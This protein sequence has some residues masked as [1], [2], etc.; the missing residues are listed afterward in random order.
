MPLDDR[1]TTVSL[2]KVPADPRADDRA[3]D[4]N[5]DEVEAEVADAI[6]DASPSHGAESGTS[7]DELDGSSAHGVDSRWA[8]RVLVLAVAIW[9]WHFGRLVA[10][11][12][13]RFGAYDFDMGFLDQAVWLLAR[14]RHFMTV[15]GLPVFGHHNNLALYLF[16]PLSWVGLATPTILSNIQTL[17]L[18]L[19]TI[20]LYLL[21][22]HRLG[23][24]WLAVPLALA[25]L[26]HPSTQWVTWELF[27]PEV[28]AMLPL[29]FAY[30]FSVTKNWR[31]F[32]ISVIATI[33]WK[34]DL[35][36]AIFVLGAIVALRGDRRRGLAVAGAAVVWFAVST[37]LVIPAFDG[38][39]GSEP[40]YV[41]LYGDLGNS[42]TEIATN[43]L[44]DPEL[45]WQ[46]WQ[47][48]DA[49][50]Y[51]ADVAS[52]Y[53]YLSFGSP[54]VLL[55]VPQGVMNTL[56]IHDFIYDDQY[57]YVAMPLVGVTIGMIETIGLLARRR[58]QFAPFLVAV[59]VGCA[60]LNTGLR[61]TSALSKDYESGIWPL[62]HN[63]R[64]IFAE[65]GLDLVPD[66]VAVSA[67]YQYVPHLTHRPEIYTF[68]NPWRELNWGVSG[69]HQRDPATIEY[70][71]LDMTSLG[72]PELELLESLIASG[73]FRVL[74]DRESVLIAVREGIGV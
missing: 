30:Y 69:E 10:L 46:H 74:F 7:P 27:H 54:A 26:A 17:S 20:P 49:G 9:V 6:A 34:E 13:R 15:R 14:G 23:N 50:H 25:F 47:D 63:P 55:G 42:T 61:G 57:H 64:Q 32:T 48:S 52:P 45:V 37:R 65:A 44:T 43:V 8:R 68:P 58:R 29:M 2:A 24:P 71:A 36:L 56:A 21:A 35:A 73:E 19:C 70:L 16:A 72:T 40:F 66:D 38:A 53:G 1:G 11:R 33:I 12:I 5:A 59:V 41:N 60:M 18:G 67:T 39:E 3:D 28:M 51:V 31:W 22:R 62:A 4:A